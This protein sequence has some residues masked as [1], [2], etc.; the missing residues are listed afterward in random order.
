MS[1]V[2]AILD[3]LTNFLRF[4]SGILL[5]IMLIITF[6]QVILRYVFHKPIMGAEEITLVMLLWFGYFAISTAV[7]EQGHMALEVF[8]EMFNIKIRKILDIIKYLL[9]IT[10]SSMMFYYGLQLVINAR[11]NV[12]PGSKISRSM[13]YLPLSISGVLIFVFSMVHLIKLLI[14]SKEVEVR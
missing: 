8:Y 14:D 11:G 4:I 6:L 7:W 10:F 12:L 13:L 9:M 5:S 3:K 1:K 2:E